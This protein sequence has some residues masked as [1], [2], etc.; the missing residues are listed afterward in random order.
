MNSYTYHHPQSIV[1]QP[2]QQSSQRQSIPSVTNVA[3]N[4]PTNMGVTT[5]TNQ[6]KQVVART[7]GGVNHNNQTTH[8]IIQQM[9]QTVQPVP[10][11]MPHPISQP[12]IVHNAPTSVQPPSYYSSFNHQPQMTFTQSSMLPPQSH[13]SS[14]QTNY[15]VPAPANTLISD[16]ISP[17]NRSS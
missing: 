14:I 12:T 9:P 1:A 4:V 13:Y 15:Y 11:P 7:L 6:S 3:N 2:G 16:N 8:T 10:Q 17:P 5:L